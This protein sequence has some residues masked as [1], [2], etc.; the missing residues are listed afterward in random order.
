MK[1]T[2]V[3]IHVFAVFLSTA[4]TFRE[5]EEDALMQIIYFLSNTERELSF[6]RIDCRCNQMLNETRL[7]DVNFVLWK[8]T[9]IA[10]RDKLLGRD[11]HCRLVLNEQYAL[12]WQTIMQTVFENLFHRNSR[13]R[14]HV[15]ERDLSIFRVRLNLLTKYDLQNLFAFQDLPCIMQHLV[16]VSQE[17]TQNKLLPAARW[18]NGSALFYRFMYQTFWRNASLPSMEAVY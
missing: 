7:Q 17:I 12:Q 5:L 1:F 8:E 18:Q 10:E 4:A 16:L 11:D 2:A 6:R 13:M 3:Y 15:R 9:I 14:T